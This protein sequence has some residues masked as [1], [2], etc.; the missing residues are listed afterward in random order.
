[1]ANANKRRRAVRL[2]TDAQLADLLGVAVESVRNA[3]CTGKGDLATIPW[4]KLGVARGSP[5][6]VDLNWV[7]DVWLEQRRRSHGEPAA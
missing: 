3:R 2:G 7:E 1:M 5:V 6:R 4:F